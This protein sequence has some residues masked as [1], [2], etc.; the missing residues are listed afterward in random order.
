MNSSTTIVDFH[1]DSRGLGEFHW[2]PSNQVNSRCLDLVS[3]LHSDI[4]ATE[5]GSSIRVQLQPL[6][7]I[8]LPLSHDFCPAE[9]K[10]KGPLSPKANF[11]YRG[12]VLST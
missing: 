5:T 7:G 10:Q 8:S 6:V 4:E 11:L 3:L 1:G 2:L 9:E 12:A